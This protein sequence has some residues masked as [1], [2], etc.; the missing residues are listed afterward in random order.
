MA[1]EL[2]TG[3]FVS[4]ELT[5][6]KKVENLQQWVVFNKHIMCFLYIKSQEELK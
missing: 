2:H 4:T 5:K 3:V 1:S 6:D